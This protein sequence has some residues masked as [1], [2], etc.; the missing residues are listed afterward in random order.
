MK[1]GKEGVFQKESTVKVLLLCMASLGVFVIFKLYQLTANINSH[2]SHKIPKLFTNI[3]IGLFTVSFL[4]LVFALIN[5]D[6]PELL[7][8]SI[9][10]HVVST[11]FD[12]VWIVMVRNRVNVILRAQKGQAS[13]LHPLAVSIFHV[14]YIQYKINKHYS[15]YAT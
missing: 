1:A 15:A 4:S 12:V 14:I 11:I 9:A 2:S 13:W 3:T 8:G 10:L 5:Y 6:Q 7:R